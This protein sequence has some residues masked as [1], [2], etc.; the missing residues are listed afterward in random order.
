MALQTHRGK[1][2]KYKHQR[3][4]EVLFLS[5]TN[6]SL[7]LQHHCC[8]P[9]LRSGFT[10]FFTNSRQDISRQNEMI[11][12]L[13]LSLS[14][15]LLLSIPPLSPP[16]LLISIPH[17]SSAFSLYF[18]PFLRLPFS[19]L[20]RVSLSLSHA[21]ALSTT[22]LPLSPHLCTLSLSPSFCRSVRCLTVQN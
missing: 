18:S 6:L 15:P 20:L 4:A 2:S 3:Y 22:S 7:S 13:L 11:L 1:A 16:L 5:T 19:P 17:I 9:H 14:A 10:D 21:L 12:S 8:L